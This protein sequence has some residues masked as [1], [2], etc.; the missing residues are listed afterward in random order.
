MEFI[1]RCIGLADH[2]ESSIIF[3]LQEMDI[4]FSLLGGLVLHSLG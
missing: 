3:P 2:M 1:L 4:T